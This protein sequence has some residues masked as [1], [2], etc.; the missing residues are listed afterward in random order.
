MGRIRF[1][2]EQRYQLNPLFVGE[3]APKAK[4]RTGAFTINYYF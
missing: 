3:G 1:S 4:L 2:G